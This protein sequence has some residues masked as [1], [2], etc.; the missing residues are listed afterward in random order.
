MA[1][2]RLHGHAITLPDRQSRKV[3]SIERALYEA[4]VSLNAENRAELIDAVV[5]FGEVYADLKQAGR[6]QP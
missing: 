2:L 6:L 5:R 4:L 3:A 1:T